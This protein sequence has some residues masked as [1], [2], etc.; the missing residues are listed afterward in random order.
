MPGPLTDEQMEAAHATWYENRRQHRGVKA[1][2]TYAPSFCNHP[3]RMKDG[4]PV[5]HECYVIP[6]KLFAAWRERGL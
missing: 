2:R 5:D 3:H 6:P 4:V 1:V